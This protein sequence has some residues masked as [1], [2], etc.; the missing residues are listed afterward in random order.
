MNERIKQIVEAVIKDK[1]LIKMVL[2][3]WNFT[4]AL[5]DAIYNL[6]I[7]QESTLYV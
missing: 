2:P 6:L 5:E 4:V 1:N 7:L 3:E